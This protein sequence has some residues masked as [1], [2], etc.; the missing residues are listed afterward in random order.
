MISYVPMS[1][2]VPGRTLVHRTPP[3]AKLI[4]LLVFV[5]AIT[6][7]PTQPWHPVAALFALALAYICARIPFTTALRLLLPVLP[8][9]TLL[10]AFLWWQDGAENALMTSLGLVA[11]LAAA[12][13]LTLTTSIQELMDALDRSLAPL[14]RVSVPVESISLAISLT[15]RLVPLMLDSVNAALDARKARGAGFS[16]TAFATPV[17]IRAVRRAHSVGEALMAR[18]AGD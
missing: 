15:I 17:V 14:A 2:Y 7:L 13:L 8:L 9:I 10:G 16:L 1:V 3:V 12:N 18:G 11:S 6:A 4:L 5:I